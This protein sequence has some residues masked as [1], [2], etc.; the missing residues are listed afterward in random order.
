MRKPS[1]VRG[2]RSR[3]RFGDERV[4]SRDKDV[5]FT[6]NSVLT[7]TAMNETN[8]NGTPRNSPKVLAI[9]IWLVFGGVFIFFAL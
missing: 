9:L 7:G 5:H 4:A 8:T 6:A 3:R 2:K 1:A